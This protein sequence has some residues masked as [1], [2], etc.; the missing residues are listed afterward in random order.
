MAKAKK[1]KPQQNCKVVEAIKTI[2]KA[3]SMA[4][5]IYRAAE[6]IAKAMRTH[7]RKTR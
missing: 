5:K 3:A 1:K 7:R 4:M 6:P 2:E